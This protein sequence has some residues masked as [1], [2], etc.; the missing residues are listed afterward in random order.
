MK[1]L[2]AVITLKDMFTGTLSSIRKQQDTF[3][4]ETKGVKEVLNKSYKLDKK[5][6]Q[7][8]LKD[9]SSSIEKN[10]E[11]L[12]NAQKSMEGWKKLTETSSTSVKNLS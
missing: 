7:S 2:N 3:K 9:I 12:K 5:E 4:K 11:D 8:A 6:L 1:Y 10:K